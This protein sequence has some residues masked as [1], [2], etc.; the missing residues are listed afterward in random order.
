MYMLLLIGCG[1]FIWQPKVKLGLLSKILFL[2]SVQAVWG[3][4]DD[5]WDE[6]FDLNKNCK[7][8]EKITKLF[9]E[10]GAHDLNKDQKR[11]QPFTGI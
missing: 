4:V 11:F 1:F 5:Y 3:G 9:K 6:D 8:E 2:F 7:Q 10:V